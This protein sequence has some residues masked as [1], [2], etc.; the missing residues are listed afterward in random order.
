MR[1]L[2]ETK[3]HP[4]FPWQIDVW[5]GP[6]KVF[7][8]MAFN[9]DTNEL[10]EYRFFVLAEAL[11]VAEYVA[12]YDTPPFT[13]PFPPG[14]RPLPPKPL[15]STPRAQQILNHY[16]PGSNPPEFS[17]TSASGVISLSLTDFADRYGFER[18]EVVEHLRE[19]GLWRPW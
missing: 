1:R 6:G 5:E 12:T 16:E 10:E 2:I 15:A 17:D 4:V 8:V 3:V 7:D 11:A 14:T 9:T 19:L 18:E 13:L